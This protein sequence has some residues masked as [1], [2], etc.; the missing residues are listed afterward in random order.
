MFSNTISHKLNNYDTFPADAYGQWY[1]ATDVLKS[2]T[3]NELSIQEVTGAVVLA[4]RRGFWSGD[5]Q[6][7]DIEVFL[8]GT[9]E[10]LAAAQERF[11]LYSQS[12]ALL[13][14]PEIYWG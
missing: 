6:R 14:R 1:V 7:E 2:K 5:P 4:S 13:D 8:W 3:I 10:Q 9:S 11:K 12:D